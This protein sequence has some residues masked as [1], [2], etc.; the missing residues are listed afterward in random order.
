MSYPAGS[1]AAIY[2]I[3]CGSGGNGGEFDWLNDAP[4]PDARKCPSCGYEPAED[5]GF[6]FCP[7]CATRLPE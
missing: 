6:I 5:S 2:E 3:P 7:M 4:V 1:E